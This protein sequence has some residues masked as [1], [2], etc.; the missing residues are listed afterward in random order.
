MNQKT[1][2]EMHNP[3]KGTR[4]KTEYVSPYNSYGLYHT[5]HLLHKHLAE[6]MQ[7]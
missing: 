2:L 5:N 4:S 7:D 6:L 3:Q 1:H